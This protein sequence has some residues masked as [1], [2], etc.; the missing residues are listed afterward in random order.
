MVLY[1]EASD[2]TLVARLLHRAKSSG[3]EDDN[4]ETIK[5]RLTTFHTHNDPIVQAY[6]AKTK[7][8]NHLYILNNLYKF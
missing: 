4:E 6:S 8:V 3:R 5:K 1:F 7:Q 2:E